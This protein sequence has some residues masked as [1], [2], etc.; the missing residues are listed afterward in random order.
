MVQEAKARTFTGAA[1]KTKGREFVKRSGERHYINH[2]PHFSVHHFLKGKTE[3]VLYKTWEEEVVISGRNL[4]GVY[5]D[6]KANTPE[7][8][9]ES[10]GPQDSDKP[11]IEKIEYR[12]RL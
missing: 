11:Y 6:L 4:R 8:L 2:A 10:E 9:R 1:G 5:E 12:V 7:V 3:K